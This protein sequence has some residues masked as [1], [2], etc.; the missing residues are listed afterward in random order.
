MTIKWSF[1]CNSF[2]K[3][4]LYNRNHFSMDPKH[5]VMKGLHCTVFESSSGLSEN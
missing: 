4:L 3:L 5:S 2:V 1:S